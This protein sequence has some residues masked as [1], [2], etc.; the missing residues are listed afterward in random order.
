MQVTD[1]VKVL[2][3]LLKHEERVKSFEST[4]GFDMEACLV[5]LAQRQ[6]DMEDEE[7][8]LTSQVA[9]MVSCQK[10]QKA[11]NPAV[12]ADDSIMHMQAQIDAT[13]SRLR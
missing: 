8:N 9:C 2:Y 5:N 4:N 1:V 3:A 11:N 12:A 10:G 7:R 13:L 6:I